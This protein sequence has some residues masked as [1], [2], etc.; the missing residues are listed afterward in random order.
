MAEETSN[1]M[2]TELAATFFVQIRADLIRARPLHFKELETS[3]VI[4]K[5]ILNISPIL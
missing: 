1:I 5:K 3:I 4:G 2:S